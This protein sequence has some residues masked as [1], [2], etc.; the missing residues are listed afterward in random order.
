MQSL[1]YWDRLSALGLYSQERRRER[2]QMVFLWKVA[3]GLVSGYQ[4][5]FY[6][7]ERRGRL[8]KIAPLC[9]S[10]PTAVKN[11][12]ESSLLVWGAKLFN[13][14][15]RDLRDTTTGTPEHLKIRLD[16]WL[17]IIPDQP[18]VP[19]RQRAAVSNS[20]LDQLLYVLP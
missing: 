19:S 18:T 13:C 7:S 16:E 2:Y 20:V 3:Q 17:N 6:Q 15:P 8:M 14:M 9:N 11:A 4:A 12:R 5:T 1:D 10:A